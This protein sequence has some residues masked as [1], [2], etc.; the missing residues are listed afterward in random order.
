[1]REGDGKGQA[2]LLLSLTEQIGADLGPQAFQHQQVHPAG[3]QEILVADGAHKVLQRLLVG[4]AAVREEQPLIGEEQHLAAGSCHHGDGAVQTGAAQ[5]IAEDAAR[6]HPG[7]GHTGPARRRAVG[8]DAAGEHDAHPA[9][10]HPRLH[11]GFALAVAADHR[12]QLAQQNA[13]RV[14]FDAGEKRGRS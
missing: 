13:E 1:M 2:A 6:H 4:G 11:Q 10:G 9:V 5:H 12:T 14:V 3:E 7:D 8:F